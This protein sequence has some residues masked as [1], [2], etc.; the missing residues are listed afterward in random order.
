MGQLAVEP[1]VLEVVWSGTSAHRG[2]HNGQQGP[3]QVDLAAWHEIEH[4][5]IS[6]WD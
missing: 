5:W 1:V 3:A 6:T 4:G 2:Y